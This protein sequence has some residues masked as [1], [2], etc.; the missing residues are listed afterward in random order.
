MY[1]IVEI[2]ECEFKYIWTTL[3]LPLI[4]MDVADK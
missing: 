3:S 4:S 1:Q 2:F